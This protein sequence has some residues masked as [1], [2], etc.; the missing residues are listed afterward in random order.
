MEAPVGTETW[1]STPLDVI[2]YIVDLQ[3]KTVRQVAKYSF[4]DDQVTQWMG[5]VFEYG[6]YYTLFTNE[7]KCF[8]VF[9]PAGEVLIEARDTLASGAQSYRA[10]L[11]SQDELTNLIAAAQR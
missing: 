8:F 7:S 5:G 11:L 9:T 10:R 1:E 4:G 6:N 2:Y 3:D